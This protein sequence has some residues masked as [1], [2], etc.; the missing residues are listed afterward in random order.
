MPAGNDV[1]GEPIFVGRTL[2]MGDQLP[3]KV[4]PSNRSAFLSYNGA[5]VGVQQYEVSAF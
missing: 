5:E 4:I 1:R 3:V 2:H